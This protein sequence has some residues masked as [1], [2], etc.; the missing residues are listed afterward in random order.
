VAP[1]AAVPAD[2]APSADAP[3][4]TSYL[5]QQFEA[6]AKAHTV[7]VMNQA[8]GLDVTFPCEPGEFV[9]EAADRAGHYLPSS[10]RAGGCLTCTGRV[11][12]GQTEM[13]EQYVLDDGHIAQ[14]FTLLCCTSVKT[15]A[16][17]LSHQQE[18]V[19]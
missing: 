2:D 15:D 3:V 16:V 6:T 1:P 8:L 12:S 9:L 4:R 13:D 14:G 7:R 5:R 11:V 17:F 10:C 19:E 18:V